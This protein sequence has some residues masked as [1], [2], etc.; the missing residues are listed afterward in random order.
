MQL[1]KATCFHGISLHSLSQPGD[2]VTLAHG[3]FLTP[4]GNVPD[5]S[6]FAPSSFRCS[7][8][9]CSLLHTL[10]REFPTLSRMPGNR[11]YSCSSFLFT[12]HLFFQHRV[13][14]LITPTFTR[15]SC[16][17]WHTWIEIISLSKLSS[18]LKS[19]VSD[20]N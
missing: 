11:V 16:N 9:S 20:F 7:F 6:N 8:A 12:S 1:T 3:R 13:P 19:C 18:L 2:Y 4:N 5:P 10:S 17:L 15:G 14:I